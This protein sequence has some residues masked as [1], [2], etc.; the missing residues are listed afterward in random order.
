MP[1]NY[2]S[3]FVHL[4]FISALPVSAFAQV[5][6]SQEAA[7]LGDAN[8]PIANPPSAR[9]AVALLGGVPAGGLLLIPDS[10]NKRVMAFDPANGDLIDAKF[11]P[12]DD[13]HLTTPIEALA[14]PDGSRLYVSDQVDDV[15]QSFDMASGAWVSTFAPAGGVNPAYRQHPRHR[16][17]PEWQ[18]AGQRS[19]WHQF[20]YGR[21]IRWRAQLSGELRSCRCRWSGQSF[22]C[23]FGRR[24]RRRSGCG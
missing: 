9:T 16:V 20:E 13:T 22:R 3:I 15:V 5:N 19:R 10:T 24:C 17:S 18:S 11:V 23:L 8:L 1:M 2:R 12:A 21:R 4:L 6:V 14:S 7:G